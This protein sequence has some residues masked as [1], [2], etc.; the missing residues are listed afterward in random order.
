MGIG[1]KDV[2]YLQQRE[3]EE[4]LRDSTNVPPGVIS[5]RRKGFVLYL[6]SDSNLVCLTSA[7]VPR[8][9]RQFGL[10][11]SEDGLRELKG[12][13]ASKGRVTGRVAIVR[14]IGDLSKVRQGDILVAITTHPDYT[15][16]MRKAA[17]II[18]DEGGITS[19]AAIVS[20]EYGIPCVVGTKKATR[21]LKDGDVVDVNA[22]EGWVIKR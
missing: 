10:S 5:D 3:V 7:D 17:A 8:A 21:I 14:G 9:L 19:H 1:S 18:T 22:S 6:D 15:I 20:R 13:P 4:F 12:M 16:A 11:E 2:S